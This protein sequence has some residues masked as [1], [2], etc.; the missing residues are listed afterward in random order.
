MKKQNFTLIELLVVIAII[1]ILAGML[2]PALQQARE[3]GRRS[4]CSNNF[5]TIGKAILFY[6]NDNHEF[7]PCS[8]S[9]GTTSPDEKY[10]FQEFMYPYLADSKKCYVGRIQKNGEKS[11]FACPSRAH[12]PGSDVYTI[13]INSEKIASKVY[14]SLRTAKKHSKSMII[15]DSSSVTN[16]YQMYSNGRFQAGAK[17]GK[18]PGTIHANGCNVLFLDWHV[19]YR[20]IDQIFDMNTH[21][22]K[23]NPQY[24]NYRN[25]WFWE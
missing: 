22:S 2:F 9:V 10:F 12:I 6:A 4:T 8:R 16:S 11:Q 14:P 20:K 3:S 24:A 7:I 25:F 1:A 13:G 17:L 19:E 5:A 21:G 15:A 23:T 18:F